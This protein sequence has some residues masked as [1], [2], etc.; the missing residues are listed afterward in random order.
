MKR[1]ILAVLLLALTVPLSGQTWRYQAMLPDVTVAA[2]AIGVICTIGASSCAAVQAGNG[3]VQATQAVCSLTGANVRV[4]YDG[5]TPTS[6]LGVVLTPGIW[7]FSGTD[8]LM[9]AQ[10]IRDDATSAVFS[11]AVQGQ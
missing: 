5:T 8:S 6:S 10:A 7:I 9:N 4:T 2:S 1:W 3:H 11:C